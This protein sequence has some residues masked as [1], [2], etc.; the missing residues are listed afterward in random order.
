MR[1]LIEVKDCQ[2]PVNL[3][4]SIFIFGV[5]STT[6]AKS[7]RIITTTITTAAITKTKTQMRTERTRTTTKKQQ[8]Q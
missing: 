5:L 8:Q 2:L 4:M 7:S 6:I 1:K 3:D